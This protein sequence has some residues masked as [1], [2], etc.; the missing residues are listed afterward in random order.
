MLKL[1]FLKHKNDM[2]YKLVEVNPSLP[3]I[4]YVCRKTWR[5]FH[6]SPERF[7]FPG[8]GRKYKLYV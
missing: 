4:C 5:N 6:L 3:R 7:K 8:P 1:I 2:T